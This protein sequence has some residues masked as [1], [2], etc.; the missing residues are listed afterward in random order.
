M[1]LISQSM[2]LMIPIGRSCPMPDPNASVMICDACFSL[3]PTSFDDGRL[4]WRHAKLQGSVITPMVTLTA[5]RNRKH[6]WLENSSACPWYLEVSINGG[7]P[8]WMV[9]NGKS[10]TTIPGK[11]HICWLGPFR[12]QSSGLSK[13]QNTEVRI[14]A[15]CWPVGSQNRPPSPC[16]SMP[17]TSL[18]SGLEGLCPRE[19]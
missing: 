13:L 11:H 9:Y 3:N 2:N 12:L 16:L 6:R 17:L 14:P 10:H 5:R 4:W 18:R 7:T 8:K 19:N 15:P 1:Q